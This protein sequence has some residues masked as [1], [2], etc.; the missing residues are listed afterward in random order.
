MPNVS[1]FITAVEKDCKKHKVYFRLYPSRWVDDC[2][3]FFDSDGHSLEH[4]PAWQQRK[5]RA[6][7]MVATYLDF[8][9]WLGILVHEYG[10]VQQWK[11]SFYNKKCIWLECDNEKDYEYFALLK[12]KN[13]NEDQLLSSCRA[14]QKLEYDCER[15]AIEIIKEYGLDN[16]INIDKYINA[17]LMYVMFYNWTMKNRVWFPIIHKHCNLVGTKWCSLKKLL[18]LP[19]DVEKHFDK[20]YQNYKA[21]QKKII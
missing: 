8:D 5:Y 21:M 2:N 9:K 4:L 7:L 14:V 10:H 19:R 15:R 20:Q 16:Y 3:G 1:K 17:S 13:P 6:A 18:I 12:Q 11:E